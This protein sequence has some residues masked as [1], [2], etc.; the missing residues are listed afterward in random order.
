MLSI[1]IIKI[2]QLVLY[3]AKIAVYCV[4]HTK[5]VS[6]HLIQNMQLLNLTPDGRIATVRL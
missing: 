1:L 4:V 5:H 3:R 2:S 6:T